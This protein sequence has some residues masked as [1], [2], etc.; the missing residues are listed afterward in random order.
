MCSCTFTRLAFRHRALLGFLLD[1]LA[2]RHKARELEVLARVD[3]V[4]GDGEGL[5]E[6][7]KSQ[8]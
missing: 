3:N 7:L 6:I 1:R 8:P 4:L 2:Y 5:G